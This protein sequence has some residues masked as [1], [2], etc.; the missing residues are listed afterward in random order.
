VDHKGD[1]RV[2]LTQDEIESLPPYNDS[3]LESKWLTTTAV[4]VPSGEARPIMHR[5]ATDRNITPLPSNRLTRDRE[6]LLPTMKKKPCR[7][8]RPCGRKLPLGVDLR[9]PQ[10]T[11]E[12]V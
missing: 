12:H 6:V 11:L 9:W 10:P 7:T 2:D 4:T 3:D 8:S 5:V 1:Y